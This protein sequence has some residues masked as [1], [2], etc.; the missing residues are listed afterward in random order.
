MDYALACYKIAADGGDPENK[1][2]DP[3][4]LD[5]IETEGEREV[6]GPEL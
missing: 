1:E 5:I 4:H 2:E 3:R 6:Q